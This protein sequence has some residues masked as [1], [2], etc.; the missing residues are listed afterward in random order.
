MPCPALRIL[1]HVAS[2][3]EISASMKPLLIAVSLLINVALALMAVARAPSAPPALRNFFSA[4]S[5][6]STGTA[7]N[8]T[9]RGLAASRPT[10]VAPLWSQLTSDD[11]A[12]MIARLRAA[13]FPAAVIRALVGSEVN[14]RYLAR[15]RAFTDPDPNTPYWKGSPVLADRLTPERMAE[16]NQL[17]LERARV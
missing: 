2:K 16:Y 6:F 7:E 14:S 8:K 13:G 11:P 9:S 15:L 5:S 12:T 10:S 1:H 3:S 4:H 17:L